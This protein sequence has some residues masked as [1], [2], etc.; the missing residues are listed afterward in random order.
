MSGPIIFGPWVNLSDDV[1]YRL[2]TGRGWIV[3]VSRGA[4]GNVYY[5]LPGFSREFRSSSFDGVEQAKSAF[6]SWAIDQGVT[7]L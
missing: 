4:F 1:A 5:V 6:D 3:S 2:C 7:L